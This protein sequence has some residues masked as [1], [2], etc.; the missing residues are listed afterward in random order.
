MAVKHGV[1]VSLISVIE[2][3]TVL[4][5]PLI[6]LLLLHLLPIRWQSSFPLPQKK[7]QAVELELTHDNFGD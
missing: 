4:C 2:Q 6:K 7:L 5:K 1:S 3:Q